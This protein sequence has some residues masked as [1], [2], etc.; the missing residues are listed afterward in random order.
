[1]VVAGVAILA[2]VVTVVMRVA[3]ALTAGVDV[4]L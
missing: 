1:M 3:V 4:V 2:G